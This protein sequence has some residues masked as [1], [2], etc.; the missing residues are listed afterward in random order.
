MDSITAVEI[1]VAA[2]ESFVLPAVVAV[3][4][5]AAATAAATLV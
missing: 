1:V 5:A 3:K 4:A 2:T